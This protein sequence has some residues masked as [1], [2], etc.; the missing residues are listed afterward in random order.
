MLLGLS[1]GKPKTPVTLSH[2]MRPHALLEHSDTIPRAAEGSPLLDQ[3]LATRAAMK[4][5]QP[6]DLH[7][8]RIWDSYDVTCALT[9]CPVLCFSST[10]QRT[11]HITATRWKYLLIS[12]N[13]ITPRQQPCKHAHVSLIHVSPSYVLSH[14]T[15]HVSSVTT[16]APRHL[17]DY[18]PGPTRT[19]P[20][21]FD[22]WALTV[23]FDIR[24]TLAFAFTIDQTSKFSKGPILLSFSRKFQ[25]WTPFLHLKHQNGSIGIF[26]IMVSSK[27]FLKASLR[28][29]LMLIQPQAF[30]KAFGLR[31]GVRDILDILA[32][33]NRPK[34]TLAYTSSLGFSRLY[35]LM[36]EFIVTQVIV[37][38]FYIVKM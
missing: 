27:A 2:L 13:V 31:E 5:L 33:C 22:P 14:A 10:C 17:V 3:N 24:L 23:D 37:L 18:W 15:R 29:L 7:S 12:S 28:D 32:Q 6:D 9:H 36:L 4:A 30:I 26:F 8:L 34:P 16:S 35:I 38:H 20:L 19:G 21:G 11:S 25:F 1:C